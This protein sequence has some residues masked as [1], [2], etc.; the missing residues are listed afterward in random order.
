MS[1]TINGSTLPAARKRSHSDVAKSAIA[2]IAPAI[3]PPARA[4]SR[5][6]STSAAR[7]ANRTTTSQR[8]GAAEPASASGAVK[9]TASG[10]QP[11]LAMVLKPG[12]GTTSSRPKTIHAQ[13]S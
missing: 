8:L 2:A 3:G 9:S 7:P 4:P 5:N 10:F 11:V 12:P 13:G 1:A 6:A